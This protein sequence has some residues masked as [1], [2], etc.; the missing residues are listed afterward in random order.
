M[1]NSFKTQAMKEKEA[2][3]Q[4]HDP[5]NLFS[6][7]HFYEFIVRISIQKYSAQ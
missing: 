3:A 4:K 2:P 5:T 6:R 1:A 7:L